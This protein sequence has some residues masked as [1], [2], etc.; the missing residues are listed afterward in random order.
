MLA[1]S[2]KCCETQIATLRHPIVRQRRL[3]RTVGCRGDCLPMSDRSEGQSES[4]LQHSRLVCDVGILLRPAVQT[5]ELKSVPHVPYAVE[6]Q[7]AFAVST[8]APLTPE[9]FED[10][11]I[12]SSRSRELGATLIS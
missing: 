8:G 5:T 4:E 1:S 3:P 11:G 6:H 9:M 2:T 7:P 10:D 12:R